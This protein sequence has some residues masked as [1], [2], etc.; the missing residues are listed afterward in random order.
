[1]SFGPR[2]ESFGLVT[3]SAFIHPSAMMA[4][5]R[6][7]STSSGMPARLLSSSFALVTTM[8][9]EL[10]MPPFASKRMFGPKFHSPV[11]AGE[12]KSFR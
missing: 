7:F 2:Y 6:S 3:F 1:M 5:P 11:E 8:Q 12:L 10:S 4:R 9:P